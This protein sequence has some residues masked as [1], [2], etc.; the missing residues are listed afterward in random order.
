MPGEL[1]VA[2][3]LGAWLLLR[4]IPDAAGVRASWL[5][6]Q[7][8]GL[9]VQSLILVDAAEFGEGVGDRRVLLAVQGA[10]DAQRRL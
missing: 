3:D 8:L 4:F 2:I 7:R 6:V 9:G 1:Q 10:A 5:A